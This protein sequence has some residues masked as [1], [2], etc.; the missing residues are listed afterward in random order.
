MTLKN[1]PQQK[2]ILLILA[3]FW[4]PYFPPLGISSL[5]SYLKHNGYDA[6][7][8]DLNVDSTLWGINRDYILYLSHC[9]PECNK[10]NIYT[11]GYNLLAYHSLAY[12]KDNNNIRYNELLKELVYKLFLFEIN[13]KDINYLNELMHK[14]FA[15]LNE[16]IENIFKNNLPDILGLSLYNSNVAS[17]LFML[18]KYKNIKPNGITILG[19]GVFAD[20]LHPESD[21]FKMILENYGNLIDKIIIGE[22]EKLLL[23]FLQNKLD[24]NKKVYSI[25]DISNEY[26]DLK[27]T[28]I[29]DFDDFDLVNYPQLATYASRSCYYQCKFCSETEQWGKYRRKDVEQIVIEMEQLCNKYSRKLFLFGDSLLDPIIDDL[30]QELILGGTNSFFDGY[31]RVSKNINDIEKVSMYRSAGFYRARLGIESGSDKILKHMDK[32]IDR[33]MIKGAVMN[34]ANAGIKTTAYFVCGFPTETKEDFEE[35]LSLIEELA[36]YIYSTECHPFWFYPKGQ[37]NSEQWIKEYGMSNLFS[38]DL[39]NLL[40]LQSWVL[41]CYPDQGD[42]LKRLHRFNKLCAKLKI[43]NPYSLSELNLADERWKKLHQSA[44]PS[45]IELQ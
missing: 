31:L 43:P 8:Y 4:V 42:I 26:L 15:Y 30:S 17:S 13:E 11:I 45:I 37:P 40:S 19:G 3:P 28:L 12:F 14:Y 1:N 23:N 32:R 18:K 7:C 39:A 10:G 29:P 41:N 20:Q 34:L 27:Q 5:K 35:T 24:P 25:S 2:E 9:I 16:S 36:D 21:N 33:E 44:V 38:D 6:K 22:G